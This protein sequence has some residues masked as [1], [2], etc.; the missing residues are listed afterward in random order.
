MTGVRENLRIE[1][2]DLD[3]PHLIAKDKFEG[4]DAL[5]SWFNPIGHKFDK[6]EVRYSTL[7]PF[8]NTIVPLEYTGP[9]PSDSSKTQFKRFDA[10]LGVFLD[11]L[12][13]PPARIHLYLA[14]CSI[15]DLPKEMQRMLP[16]PSFLQHHAFQQKPKNPKYKPRIKQ[17]IEGKM[18]RMSTRNVPVVYNTSIWIGRPPTYTSLHRDPNPNCF[19]QLAGKKKL[20]LYPPERGLEI[21]QRVKKRIGEGEGDMSGRIRGEEMMAGK[22]REELEKEVWDTDYDEASGGLEARLDRGDGLYI[23][24]GWWHSVKGEGGGIVASVSWWAHVE[25]VGNINVVLI[26]STGQLVVSDEGARSDTTL[27]PTPAVR[28]KLEG[29]ASSK[30]FQARRSFTL[31]GVP[32]ASH[33]RRRTS[34]CPWCKLRQKNHRSM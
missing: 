25:W 29:V 2:R 15:A 31:E 5:Y 27:L 7:R 8:A 10:P 17:K 19:F 23:P 14:Q 16:H 9:D 34:D 4:I 1:D 24:E 13:N 32:H 6:H 30:E 26:M 18:R 12:E 3:T 33:R 22:E 20:R 28:L 21:F 11:Y